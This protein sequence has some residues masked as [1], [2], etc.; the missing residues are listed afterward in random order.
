MKRT[1]VVTGG[2]SG[3]GLALTKQLRKSGW[4]VYELS[5]RDSSAEGIIHCK[6]DVTDEAGIIKLMSEIYD[7][8]QHIDLVVNCAGFGISGAAEFTEHDE[9]MR[10][11]DVNLVGTANVCKAAA[12]YMRRH[13]RGLI[14]NISSVAAVMPIP[15]Q[16]WYSVTKAGI[17][18]YTCGLANELRPYGVQVCAVMLG[19]AKTGFTSA[20]SKSIEGDEEY[21]GRISRSVAVMEH[22]EQNGYSTDEV[23]GYI[24]KLVGK[25][26]VKPLYTMGLGYKAA[27]MLDRILPSGAKNKLLYMV[28]G[29]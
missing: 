28:Y 24:M 29:K 26:K 12:P 9:V 27:C 4:K 13:K 6:A 3:I 19:D 7:K 20:R 17:N 10:Q 18:S 15:F 11:L 5:R 14:I 2:S 23:A 22:D 8:E 25:K 16:I 1:A 21:G